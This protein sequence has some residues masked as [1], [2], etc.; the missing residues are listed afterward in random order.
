[1]IARLRGVV[2][3]PGLPTILS[4]GLRPCAGPPRPD[5]ASPATYIHAL[6]AAR[7]GPG[8]VACPDH[9]S[10]P[11]PR[12]SMLGF[13]R[14]VCSPGFAAIP[15][16]GASVSPPYWLLL[17]QWRFVPLATPFA[18]G[19]VPPPCSSLFWSHR[20]FSVRALGL[21]SQ[22]L[23]SCFGRAPALR[24]LSLLPLPR[25]PP[26]LGPLVRVATFAG[27]RSSALPSLVDFSSDYAYFLAL[28]LHSYFLVLEFIVAMSF[29]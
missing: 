15:P 10:V 1:M 3:F 13:R 9:G 17:S 29:Q 5:V 23:H 12:V 8:G 28:S 21:L 19:S 18:R 22:S 6:V 27:L 2:C 24:D 26:P 16:G 4:C 11:R 25:F 20:C 14:P 7:S